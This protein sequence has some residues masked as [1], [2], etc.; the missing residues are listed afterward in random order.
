MQIKI[1]YV[2]QQNF[3]TASMT[4]PDSSEQSCY[5]VFIECLEKLHLKQTKTDF[6]ISIYIHVG[7]FWNEVADDFTLPIIGCVV[8]QCS[9]IYI[10]ID[11]NVLWTKIVY[12]KAVGAFFH[13]R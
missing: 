7:S 13:S 10:L 3:H 2:A 8:E 11:L 9:S 6:Q 4:F 1:A 5:S 12:E